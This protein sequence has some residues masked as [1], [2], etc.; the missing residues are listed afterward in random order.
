LLFWDGLSYLKKYL[1]QVERLQGEAATAGQLR[2]AAQAETRDFRE[3]NRRLAAK[4][5]VLEGQASTQTAALQQR[6]AAA[7]EQDNHV[8]LQLAATRLENEQLAEQLRTK[9]AECAAL[10]SDL[11]AAAAA[12]ASFADESLFGAAS[13]DQLSEAQLLQRRARAEALKRGIREL[14]G[15]AATAEQRLARE[16]GGW[17]ERQ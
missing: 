12:S 15:R 5:A 14:E 8:A 6:A 2:M 9:S 7:A 4:V 3:E 16:V 10:G 11:A 1:L 17:V 13:E